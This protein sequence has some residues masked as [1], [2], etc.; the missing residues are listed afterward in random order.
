[1][2]IWFPKEIEKDE[3]LSLYIMKCNLHMATLK[4]YIRNNMNM[5]SL[6]R[7][8]NIL[9]EKE[10]LDFTNKEKFSVMSVINQFLGALSCVYS[11][12]D[13]KCYYTI[14]AMVKCI[15]TN[16]DLDF[17]IR[18]IE[19][20]NDKIPPTNLIRHSYKKFCEYVGGIK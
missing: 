17:V 18:L 3:D 14:S 8:E 7:I 5:P 1:M 20:G 16:N 2:I 15:N 9:K 6:K 19:Y 4:M 12:K 13:K 11:D 10:M